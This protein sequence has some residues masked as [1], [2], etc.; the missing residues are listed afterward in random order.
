MLQGGLL[1]GLDPNP[2]AGWARCHQ[3]PASI[4]GIDEAPTTASQRH[5]AFLGLDGGSQVGPSR[6]VALGVST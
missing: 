3:L 1:A 6:A 5:G 2:T 4:T